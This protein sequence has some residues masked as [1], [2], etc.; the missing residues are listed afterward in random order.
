MFAP[1]SSDVWLSVTVVVEYNPPL[2]SDPTN[3]YEFVKEYVSE[4]SP[5]MEL[6]S[7]PDL[8]LSE[9]PERVVYQYLGLI[10]NLM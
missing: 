9:N 8:S 5:G 7:N 1:E 10:L 6:L 2:V 4:E 3:V